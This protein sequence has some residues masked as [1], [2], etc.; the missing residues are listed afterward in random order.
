M[1][2]QAQTK[3]LCNC[4]IWFESLDFSSKKWARRIKLRSQSDHLQLS[5]A[6][7]SL[8]ECRFHSSIEYTV[9]WG[10]CNRVSRDYCYFEAVENSLNDGFSPKSN[11]INK[12]ELSGTTSAYL[13]IKRYHNVAASCARCFSYHIT[14]CRQWLVFEREFSKPLNVFDGKQFIHSMPD[15]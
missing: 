6:S 1:F 2:A 12:Q 10:A 5:S 9:R 7:V 13:L 15:Y 11:Q 14:S 4:R 3:N 8:L